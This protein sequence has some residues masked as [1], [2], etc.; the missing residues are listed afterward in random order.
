MS[1]VEKKLI[2]QFK[3]LKS[4]GGIQTELLLL[5]NSKPDDEL[6]SE[7][8]LIG[9]KAL[10]PEN[11][12]LSR[13]EKREMKFCML[14][15]Q[16][17]QFDPLDSVLYIRYPISDPFFLRFLRSLEDWTIIT[18][19]QDKERYSAS[20]FSS[21]IRYLSEIVYGK[22]VR[23]N[24]NA[25]VGVTQE[26][27]D[28][29]RE[30]SKRNGQREGFVNGNGIDVESVP[31]RLAPTVVEKKEFLFVG[32]AY[33]P[34]ALDRIIV[35]L[36]KYTRQLRRKNVELHVVGESEYI[37]HYKILV[38]K[39]GLQDAVL[40]Y[41]KKSGKDLDC[42]FDKAHI[43]IG[44]LGI[45]RKG[46]SETSELK[47][48]EYCARGIPFICS[49][50]DADFPADFPYVLRVPSN[51]DPVDIEQ[52]VSFAERVCSEKAHPQLMREYAMNNL[53]WS[54]KMKKLVDFINEILESKVRR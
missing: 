43:A 38:A 4:L 34:H 39:R 36:S 26:I 23:R 37:K 45:H 22:R 33:R 15:D 6:Q 18:E 14:I 16:L 35:G 29:E 53:D 1:G 27:L 42:F 48:R 20:L 13:L 30:L 32:S 2:S 12:G 50:P 31:V 17:K 5:M 47:A 24:V 10:W 40:F 7:L 11:T 25:F 54:I 41:G 9:A 19:H 28:Y 3:A 52:L 8:D 44:S 21:P 49:V 51:D 46:L